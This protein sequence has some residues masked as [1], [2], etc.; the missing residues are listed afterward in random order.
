MYF[1]CKWIKTQI[2]KDLIFFFFNVDM[3]TN[4]SKFLRSRAIRSGPFFWM[5]YLLNKHHPIQDSKFQSFRL[6]AKSMYGLRNKVSKICF[7]CTTL[8]AKISDFGISRKL[9]QVGDANKDA[10]KKNS[11]WHFWQLR[12]WDESPHRHFL[13]S[14]VCELCWI[15]V[16][17]IEL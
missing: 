12:W 8:D 5:N 17:N 16:L 9:D 2:V 13:L 7:R 10:S 11:G 3:W 1:H 15:S 14:L 6:T 4:M